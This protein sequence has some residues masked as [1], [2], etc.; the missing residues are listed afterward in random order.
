MINSCGLQILN[1]VRLKPEKYSLSTSRNAPSFCNWQLELHRHWC[2]LWSSILIRLQEGQFL[3]CNQTIN[4]QQKYH[5]GT[6][7]LIKLRPRGV[8]SQQPG[9]IWGICTGKPVRPPKEEQNQQ[10][11]LAG[12]CKIFSPMSNELTHAAGTW[13]VGCHPFIHSFA[14]EGIHKSAHSE[15]HFPSLCIMTESIQEPT[16]GDLWLRLQ[17]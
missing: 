7:A 3:P 17:S 11:R 4:G 8:S 14:H 12:E 13:W 16:V 5:H 10:Q 9:R 1:L 6:Q 2:T 15:S